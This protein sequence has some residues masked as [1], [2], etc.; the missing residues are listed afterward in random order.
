Y[1]NIKTNLRFSVSEDGALKS[2][3]DQFARQHKSSSGKE[4]FL[5]ICDDRSSNQIRLLG[6]ILERVRLVSFAS[7]PSALFDE[8]DLRMFDQIIRLV[9]D[10]LETTSDESA[11]D[12]LQKISIVIFNF[13][14]SGSF[15]QA[16]KVLAVSSGFARADQLWEKLTL[17]CFVFAKAR[18]VID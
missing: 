7:V 15:I 9:K 18:Q 11:F 13:D 14:F 12:L 8:Q 10:S 5:L 4:H 2:A 16:L 6:E 1:A 3:F 17:D